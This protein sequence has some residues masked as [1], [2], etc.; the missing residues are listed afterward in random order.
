MMATI[1]E[2]ME[3]AERT[4]RELAAVLAA[5]PDAELID[6]AIRAPV[7]CAD[8]DDLVFDREDGTLRVGR[9]I[10]PLAVSSPPVDVEAVL[11][12][13]FQDNP[14]ALD[15]AIDAVRGQVVATVGKRK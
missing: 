6:S 10:G 9:M 8:G 3:A 11:W 1:Q 12:R 14:A 5:Y 7:R 13:L 15:K 2:A 4:T